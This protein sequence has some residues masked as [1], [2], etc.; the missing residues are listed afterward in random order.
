MEPLEQW[1]K[2]RQGGQERLGQ[3]HGEQEKEEQVG[4]PVEDHYPGHH[5]S[6]EN[7]G[8]WTVELYRWIRPLAYTVGLDRRISRRAS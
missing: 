6:P 8:E 1:H 3:D 7:K 4:R 2:D 5:L